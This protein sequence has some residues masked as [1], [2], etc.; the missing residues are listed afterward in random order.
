GKVTVGINANITYS[1]PAKGKFLLAKATETS[2]S[3]SLC[4]YTVDIFDE[5]NEVL[6]AK[7]NATGFIK[8]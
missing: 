4:N 3:R 1:K 7:F 2:A 8:N 6:I 5:D